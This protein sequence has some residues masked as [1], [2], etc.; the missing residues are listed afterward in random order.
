MLKGNSNLGYTPLEVASWL[1]KYANA[2]DSNLSEAKI[3][4]K[5]I[6]SPE[7][8]RVVLDVQIQSGLGKFFASKIRSGALFAIYRVTGDHAALEQAV[9][10]YRKKLEMH[11]PPWRIRPRAFT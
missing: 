1:E 5:N 2:A 4:A 10:V 11:G 3:H 7:Y 6:V 8:R 9:R